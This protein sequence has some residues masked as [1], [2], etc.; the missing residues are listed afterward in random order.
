MTLKILLSLSMCVGIW[1]SVFSEAEKDD[2]LS[3]Y[4]FK[5]VSA[6]LACSSAIVLGMY[7]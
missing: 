1:F 4:V 2:L 6:T 5:I 3:S 7:L